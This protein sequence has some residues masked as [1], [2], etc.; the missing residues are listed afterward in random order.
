MPEPETQPT[1]PAAPTAQIDP[2]D[3]L[4]V[5]LCQ[6]GMKQLQEHRQEMQKSFL[7]YELAML[8]GENVV[9]EPAKEETPAVA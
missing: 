3:L 5:Q 6:Q 8:S 2:N 1:P 7:A 4:A 9:H